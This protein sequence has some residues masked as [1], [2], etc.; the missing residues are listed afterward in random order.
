[1]RKILPMSRTGGTQRLSE[2]REFRAGVLDCFAPRL[3]QG[4]AHPVPAP[5]KF[6]SDGKRRIHMARRRDIE[7]EDL[8]HGGFVRSSG[9]AKQIHLPATD[10][11]AAWRTE[12]ARCEK[13]YE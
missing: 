7:K 3:G 8:R 1:M 11:P 9:A 13:S 4:V 6:A 2:R 12:R 5:D 10:L